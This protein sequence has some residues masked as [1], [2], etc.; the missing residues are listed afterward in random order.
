MFVFF[1]KR[2]YIFI[3]QNYK[4]PSINT[5]SPIDFPKKPKLIKKKTI[6]GESIDIEEIPNIPNEDLNYRK[7]KV[8]VRGLNRIYTYFS[9]PVV[10]FLNHFVI[11]LKL[12]L[13]F[14][15]EFHDI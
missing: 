15:T 3:F 10:K 14:C 9:A 5:V 7:T 2:V 4:R 6:D 8:K 13:Y 1:K 12:I 11:F